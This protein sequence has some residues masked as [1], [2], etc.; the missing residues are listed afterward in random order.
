MLDDLVPTLA[1]NKTTV[2]GQDHAF[3]VTFFDEHNNKYVNQ[4][5]NGTEEEILMKKKVAYCHIRQSL[6]QP[7]EAVP[8]RY[9]AIMSPLQPRLGKRATLGITAAIWVWSSILSAP[10]LIYFTTEMDYLPDGSIRSP[11]KKRLDCFANFSSSQ[12]KS[13]FEENTIAMTQG[14]FERNL[15]VGANHKLFDTIQIH[16][17]QAQVKVSKFQL[18]NTKELP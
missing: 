16:K 18:E 7:N 13:R 5:Q 6:S 4:S 3:Y 2:P 10:N 1:T 9:V 14:N 8:I 12:Q 17:F 15:Q 11:P